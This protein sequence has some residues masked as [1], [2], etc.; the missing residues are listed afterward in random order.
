MQM[1]KKTKV[2]KTGLPGCWNREVNLRRRRQGL[3]S[4]S[5]CG[6]S[7]PGQG[8]LQTR[9]EDE[10]QNSVRGVPPSPHFIHEL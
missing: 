1:H 6:S 8:C 2:S 5:I 10:R 7:V 3:E 4:S 9:G